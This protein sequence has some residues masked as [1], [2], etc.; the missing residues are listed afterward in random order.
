MKTQKIKKNNRDFS[1]HGLYTEIISPED[2]SIPN[3]IG[4]GLI[5]R[6]SYNSTSLPP[7]LVSSLVMSQDVSHAHN[8]KFM[9]FKTTSEQRTLFINY[10]DE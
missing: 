10:R 7:L 5:K 6:R 2:A 9:I 4:R 1:Y 3:S 8:I